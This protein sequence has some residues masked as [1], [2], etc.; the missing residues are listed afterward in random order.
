M[1]IQGLPDYLYIIP[2]VRQ[3]EKVKYKLS[4]ILIS[5]CVCRHFWCSKSFSLNIAFECLLS[6]L[7]QRQSVSYG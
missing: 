3:Q 2:D 5:Y 4:D 7:I 6:W 1:S